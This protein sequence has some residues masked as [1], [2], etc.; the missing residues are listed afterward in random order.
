MHDAPYDANHLARALRRASLGRDDATFAQ[1]VAG[2]ALSYGELFA[3]A[4][5]MAA[6]LA[7]AG[8][9]PG[10]RVALQAEKSLEA[11]QLYL[12]A[13]LA[14]AVF[15]PLNTAYTESEVAY[16]LGD[17]EPA[18]FVC[19]PARLEA[20][21][22]TAEAAGVRAL[23]TLG[24]DGAGTLADAAGAQA[25][26]FKA[27]PRGA[28]DL[29]AILYTS[30]TTGRSKGAMLSHANL[31]SNAEALRECWRFTQD[32]VLIHALPIFHT[33]GLFVATN[34]ALA[35]G[36]S[37][38]FL[39]G[40]DADAIVG[41]MGRA[42]V[43][44][45]VPTFYVR[46]LDHPGLTRERAERMR[47]FVSG[48][49]PLLAETHRLWRERTGHAIL[50]R[51]G[52]T[53]TNMNTSNPY[54]GERR[55]GTV[56]FPLPGVELRVTGEDGRPL[57][58]GE[59]GAV[60]VRGPNVFQGYWR[61]PD[62]TAQDMRE[63][64]F[65]VTG[66]VGEID[67]DGYL[68]IVGRSKD[69]II[70]GGYN[71]YPKEVEALIDAI[72]G[73]RESAVIGLPHPDFGEGVAAVVVPQGGATLSPEAILEPLRRD[74]APLQAAQA[75]VLRRRAAAQHDGQGAEERPARRPRRDLRGL[76]AAAA[77]RPLPRRAESRGSWARRRRM[78]AFGPPCAPK[79]DGEARSARV[80]GA[81]EASGP[82]SPDADAT[83]AAPAL[84]LCGGG[85]LGSCGTLSTRARAA[86][87]VQERPGAARPADPIGARRGPAPP[88][89][90]SPRG[91][92]SDPLATD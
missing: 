69:L 7:A 12:G 53:E 20:L 11:L 30:G 57:P 39:P 2:E 22:S 26:G 51:Y 4:E 27:V 19:D 1:T 40:F 58:A 80:A 72:E 63:D 8:V 44:M 38:V 33:H 45:G 46:L 47:L 43:L 35:S 62:K 3:G 86:C 36:A 65:F 29:A 15:L 79:A 25:P 55:A 89:A 48:S 21:A 77:P 70:T 32:D 10:D 18:A 17:A 59:P 64:G 9:G 67:A 52:M 71:V 91:F 84:R 54:D 68:S 14:G 66:D 78:A 60:E 50:E 41:A 28:G 23:L 24:A 31:A 13:V 37:L 16:F 6:A 56:G 90:P 76:I 92:P 42:T 5:R 75:R 73:V 74:L 82:A 83:M 49:A 88:I 34:V 61:M 87:R 81:F 85:I